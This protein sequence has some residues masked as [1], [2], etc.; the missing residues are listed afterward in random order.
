VILNTAPDSQAVMSNVAEI[1]EFRI[2][3]SAKAFNILSS[4]LYANKI[5]AIIRELSCNAVDSHTAAGKQDTPFDVHLPNTIDPTFRIRDYGTGLSHAHVLSIYTTYFESTKTESNQFIGALGLGSKSPFSYTDNFT[6]TAIRDGARNVYSAF[7]NGEGV[8]SIA[9]MHSESTDQPNGVEVQFAVTDRW[10][11]DKFRSE[12]REVYTY[13]RLRPV[14]SGGDREFEFR[15]VEYKDKNIIPGVHYLAGGRN[16][17]AV[18]GNISYPIDVPNSESNLGKLSRL[19]GCGL[20]MHF[21]IGELDFQASREGLSYIPSTIDAIKRKLIALESQLAVHLS[22]EA[23]AIANDWEKCYFLSRRLNDTLWSEAA[24]AYLSN[25]NFDMID[26]TSTY[27]SVKALSIDIKDLAARYNISILAFEKSNRGA[28]CHDLKTDKDYKDKTYTNF[29]ELW[30]FRV[31]QGVVFVVN[32]TKKGALARAKYHWRNA[33]SKG[34]KLPTDTYSHNVYVLSPVIKGHAMDTVGF[35]AELRNPP[36]V[37]IV[38]ASELVEKERKN[39]GGGMG[40]NVSIMSLRARG[41]GGYHKERELVWKDAGKAADFDD[42]ET[43]YYLP[44]KG[45]TVET[46]DVAIHNLRQFS[47]L[48]TESGIPGLHGI[49]IYGVRKTDIEYIKTQTNWINVQDHIR[50]VLAK[51]D[52]VVVQNCALKQIDANKYFRYNNDIAKLVNVDSPYVKFVTQFNGID[53]AKV[54]RHSLERLCR[55]YATPVD[56][57]SVVQSITGELTAIRNRY[58]LLSSL[59]DYDIN[60][61]AVAQYIDLIDNSKGI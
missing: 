26:H 20:E 53:N 42:S 15:D 24:R 59:R 55:D 23:N 49:T 6:V 12:A 56:V 11:Y 48:V 1:G 45:F 9:L 25:S 39:T 5:R 22:L 50:A 13:F 17:R 4:G 44:L 29:D 61:M 18:M 31:E 21:D 60:A 51:L 16:S 33:A 8:P 46:T 3:N 19:L 36:A 37:Q 43:Y 2:R 27:P 47:D 32:D 54:E 40:T 28:T 57:E 35:F 38:N 41:Y 30:K 34:T 7:I 58:P 52:P 10:D 14:V